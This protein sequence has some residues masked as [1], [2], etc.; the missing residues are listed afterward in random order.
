MSDIDATVERVA[1]A[2]AAFRHENEKTLCAILAK[3]RP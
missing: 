1:R 2:M 3:R